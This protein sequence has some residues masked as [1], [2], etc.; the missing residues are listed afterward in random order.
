MST[1]TK[2]HLPRYNREQLAR[3]AKLRKRAWEH[4]GTT[5]CG[6]DIT[7]SSKLTTT[8]RFTSC[9]ACKNAYDAWWKDVQDDPRKLHKYQHLFHTNMD[10]MSEPIPF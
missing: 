9:I 3:K 10:P 8:R 4:E 5:E 2:F 7:S 1:P 6:R